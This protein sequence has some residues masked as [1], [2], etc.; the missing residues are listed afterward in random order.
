MSMGSRLRARR[1]GFTL[2]ELL[3]VIAIIAVL[4][5]LLLPAV[6]Q[7]REA[8]RRTQCRN[9]L[10]QLGLAFHNYHDAYTRFTNG[11][12]PG[13]SKYLVGW[14]AKLFPYLDQ[15]ARY[16][17]ISQMAGS[18]D[19]WTTLMPYR[20]DTAP[21]NGQSPVWGPIPGLSCPSSAQGNH[22]PDIPAV[23][24]Y[25]GRASQG[26]LHYRGCGGRYEDIVNASDG[27]TYYYARSGTIYPE[28]NVRIADIT[29]GTSN[30]ILLGE[31]SSSRGWPSPAGWGGLQP[32]TWGFYWYGTSPPAQSTDTKRLTIDSKM[33]HWP[34]NYRGSFGTNET[35]YTSYHTGGATFLLCDGSVRF[36][37]ENINLNTLKSLGTRANA[38]V[39]G[40]F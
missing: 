17:T 8:A 15:A 12:S 6:Q 33:I 23:S 14:P 35:P 28:S 18:A 1:R 40:E 21:H 31:T 32:W 34:I 26:A 38:E 7:A 13:A 4:I 10:K 39:V 29:D 2:I 24:P 19:A 16:N 27:S 5:A 30:T 25:L 22:A 20:F 9:N 3:V 11:S 36:I 37:S